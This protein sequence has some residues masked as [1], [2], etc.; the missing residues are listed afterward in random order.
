MILGPRGSAKSTATSVTYV[1]WDIGRNPMVRYLLAFNSLEQQGMAFVRQI[2]HVITENERY[3]EI[4]GDLY[5]GRGERWTDTEFI[6]R[7]PTP[8]GGMKDPTVVA[9]GIGSAVPSKRAD[10]VILDDLVTKDNAYTEAMRA[11]VVAFVVQTL[12]PI[13]VPGGR[14]IVVGSRWDPDDLYA[15]LGRQWRLKFP[16]AE[17]ISASEVLLPYVQSA[18][19]GGAIGTDDELEQEEWSQELAETILERAGA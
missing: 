8:P 3:K 19:M 13:L 7:R 1:T 9:V 4:F 10:K 16:K 15:Y 18:V 17:P 14:R 11:K 5:P 12:F 2:K 6:V